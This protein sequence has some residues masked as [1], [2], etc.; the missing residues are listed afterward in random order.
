MKCYAYLFYVFHFLVTRTKASSLSRPSILFYDGTSPSL[1]IKN[2]FSSKFPCSMCTKSKK[3]KYVAHTL[4]P[5]PP[6]KY[7]HERFST[8]GNTPPKKKKQPNPFY[9]MCGFNL[10]KFGRN[11]IKAKDDRRLSF[12][13]LQ[14][15]IFIL[16]LVWGRLAGVRG[17]KNKLR[18]RNIR[19][20]R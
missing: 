8:V 9:C 17:I 5:I 6:A 4:F 13:S 10:S 14:C 3:I 20:K 18:A 1:S 15:F 16:L 19:W 12:P 11:E 7:R 2:Q